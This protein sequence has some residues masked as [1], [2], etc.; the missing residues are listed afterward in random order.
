MTA[1][2]DRS[3]L[4]RH[5]TASGFVLN[6]DR[7][8][9][10]LHHRKL[11]VWLYPGGHIEQGET[12][13]A[14]VLREIFEETGI[15]AELLG[16]RDEE[17]ADVETDVTVLHQPYRVLCEYIDDKRGPHY[18]LDLIYVTATPLL[19]CPD[20]REVENARFFS[21][22]ETAALQMFPNFRRM[23]DRIFADEAL[24]D[25]VGKKVSS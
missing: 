13:D 5:F 24:W 15:Q 10:L 11:G 19:A 2:L 22:Q 21:H 8:M 17:L 1:P 3:Q 23:V 7:K 12:P 18:H 20:D 16:E 14:A 4:D 9:L 25:L 6:P